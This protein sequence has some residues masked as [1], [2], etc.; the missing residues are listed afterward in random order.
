MA[1]L[2]AHLT[3]FVALVWLWQ[4]CWNWNFRFIRKIV[5]S[6]EFKMKI[7][8]IN[9]VVCDRALHF[10]H[11]FTLFHG[12]DYEIDVM[13]SMHICIRKTN[14][15]IDKHLYRQPSCCKITAFSQYCLQYGECLRI[16]DS[17]RWFFWDF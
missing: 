8:K 2:R 14:R 6:N 12:V 17:N 13:T 10:W 4:H 9:L 7:T 3:H 15:M 16:S 11:R 1:I 5:C